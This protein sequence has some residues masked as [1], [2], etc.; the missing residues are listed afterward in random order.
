M[1]KTQLLSTALYPVIAAVVAVVRLF[2]PEAEVL[3]CKT[4]RAIFNPQL[5]DALFEKA[6]CRFLK[7]GGA[8][9]SVDSLVVPHRVEA[10]VQLDLGDYIQRRFYL[11]GCPD[12]MPALL[13]FCDDTTLF[14]D[15]GA[16]VGL[17]SIG[18]AAVTPEQNV[19]AF[20]PIPATFRRMQENMEANY[21]SVHAHQIAL[22]DREG[23]IKFATIDTD[24]GSATVEADY[25]E[26]RMKTNRTPA[27]MRF[28]TCRTT[29][30][31]S[32]WKLLPRPALEGI[33]KI[34]A[35]IDVEGHEPAVLTGM[36]EF[37]RASPLDILIICETHFQNITRVRELVEPHGF[38][39]LAPGEEAFGSK[40]HFG[41]AQDLTF[42]RC[43]R[44]SDETVLNSAAG[45][46]PP[47]PLR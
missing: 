3:F 2:P 7:P 23:E 42:Y 14:F 29:T 12:F 25:L 44:K 43:A 41:S 8:K 13:R 34:A 35:K 21:P 45:C 1:N 27:E 47:A 20:E 9:V 22:S 36:Q 10:R 28:E 6:F 33:R 24:S 32:F 31:D 37:L 16:N 39:L 5:A 4:V 17:V 19:H 11:H 26:R 40:E 30:F 38:S 15:I 46:Q 18:V